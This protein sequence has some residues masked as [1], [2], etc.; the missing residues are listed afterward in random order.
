MNFTKVKNALHR[1]LPADSKNINSVSVVQI[2]E[3]LWR[4]L[5]QF[6]SVT[7]F[8]LLLCAEVGSLKRDGCL[9]MSESVDQM[10]KLHLMM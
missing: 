6:Q 10:S 8:Y 5:C 2:G 3:L 4:Y 1:I 9:W 7:L